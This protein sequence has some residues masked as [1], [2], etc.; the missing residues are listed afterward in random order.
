MFDRGRRLLPAAA[1][2]LA[3][4]VTDRVGAAVERA[5]VPIDRRL[6]RRNR[7]L[8]PIPWRKDRRGGKISYGEWA[9]VIGLMQSL[10]AT[11]VDRDDPQILDVGCGTGLVGLATLPL[12]GDGGRCVGVDVSVENIQFC[13]QH[14]RDRRLSFELLEVPNASYAPDHADGPVRWPVADGSQHLV[15]ALSVWTHL[16]PA[17]ADASMAEVARVLAPGGRAIISF[18]VNDLADPDRSEA[19]SISEY[20]RTPPQH[21]AFTRPVTPGW[22]TPEWTNVPEQAIAVDRSTLHAMVEANGLE[23]ERLHPGYWREAPGLYF[24]DIAII[25]RPQG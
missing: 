7:N 15:T 1:A 21:W 22:S 2:K 6:M 12:L 17:T 10:V 11:H 16:D 5:F 24:Q 13:R 3:E 4:R 25:A 9:W 20:H 19:P 8:A 18:F 14:Y 23:L